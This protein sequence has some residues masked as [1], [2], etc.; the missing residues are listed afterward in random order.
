[1]IDKYALQERLE[2]LIGDYLKQENIIL[3]DLNFQTQRR[4]F[5]LRILVDEPKGRITLDR[6]GYLN[7]AISQLLDREDLIQ[8]RYALE[9]SSPGTDRPLLTP[10][11]FSRCINRRVRVF[12][13]QCQGGKYEISG[14]I[15]SVTDAGLNLDLEG[16]IQHI[17]FDQIKKAKQIIEEVR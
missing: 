17:S 1:M 8:A 10:E 11:D 16:Q 7:S 13:N 2:T 5:I 6:C 12:F 14:V 4:K 3:V 9:I 15:I